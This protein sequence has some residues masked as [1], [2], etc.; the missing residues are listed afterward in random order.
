MKSIVEII[1]DKSSFMQVLES[2]HDGVVLIDSEKQLLYANKSINDMFKIASNKELYENIVIG[3]YLFCQNDCSTCGGCSLD[4]SIK[5]ACSSSMPKKIVAEDLEF[6]TKNGETIY[7]KFSVIPIMNDNQILMFIAFDDVTREKNLYKELELK[8]FRLKH[9]AESLENSDSIVM[10][11]ANSVEAKDVLTKGHISRVAYYAEQIGKKLKMTVREINIL[12][13]GAI[14]HDIG[15]IGTP[16]HILNKPGPLTDEE[17]TVMK[18][19]PGDGW[20]ILK[21][22]KTFKEVGNIVRSHHEKLD[23][24][25]YPDGLTADQIDTYTRIVAIVDI[26][27]ALAAERP[28]RKALSREIALSIIYKDVEAGKLDREIADILS[29]VTLSSPF[30]AGIFV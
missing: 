30:E 12:K 18:K 23:G 28:Y 5:S 19:H 25:G 14:L 8:H 24:S 21:S 3:N 22:L 26:Y 9:L 10:A 2:I 6:T 13:K 1:K 20:N 27:D 15:K 11:V 4:Y 17:F 29:E 16:D 7:L